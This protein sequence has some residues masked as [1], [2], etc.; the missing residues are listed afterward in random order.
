LSISHVAHPP[1]TPAA[2]VQI[3]AALVAGLLADQHPDLAQLPLEIVDAGWDNALLRLGD[4]LA[5]RLPRRAAAA[6]LV[7]HEQR[8]LPR[9]AE[10]LTLPVP[11]PSRTGSPGR[12]YP[13]H[14]SVVPWLPGSAADLQPPHPAQAAPFAAFLRSLHLPAPA[15]APANPVRGVP[16]RDRAAGV[17]ERMRRLEATTSHI[18]PQLRQLWEAAVRAP[19]DA[20]ATWLHGDLH[21]RNVLV[22]EGVITGVIDWGDITSGDCATDLAAIWM[23]FSDP[24]AR[25]SALDAYGALSAATLLRARGW[26]ILFGLVLL[27]TG[28]ADNPRNALIGARTLSRVHT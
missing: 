16:L 23:L 22:E 8:W 14:W 2:E 12:G 21:P 28:L 18:T 24:Q 17:E 5:V 15:D 4:Q 7:I 3:D 1:G 25:A 11:A 10:G 19:L 6:P 27:E 20:P 13:W 9:L 26:A